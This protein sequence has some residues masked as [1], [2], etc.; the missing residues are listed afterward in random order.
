M[1]RKKDKQVRPQVAHAPQAHQTAAV[2]SAPASQWVLN[3]F[4]DIVLFIGAPLVVMGAFLPLRS[5]FT[6]QQIAV[7][8]LAFFT[9]GHHFP[10]FLR[11]YGDKELFARYRW[12]FLIAPPLIF[13]AALW[14][15]ARQLHGLLIF[16]A[17]WDIWHVLMQHYGFMRIY[18]SKAGAVSP[19]T[20]WMD[21]ALSISWYLALI[22]VSPHYSHN[23]LSRAAQVGLPLMSPEFLQGLRTGMTALSALLTLTYVGYHLWLWKQGRPVSF[24][25]LALLGIFLGATWYLYVGLDDF[26]VGFTVWSGFHCI[27]YYGIVWV[28]NRNRV[29]KGSP[30]TSFIRFLFRPSPALVVLYSAL[31][32]AYGSINYWAG[33]VPDETLRKLLL[34]FITTSNAL[35]YYFD[36]FIWKMRDSKTRQDLEIADAERVPI[37]AMGWLKQVV[38]RI[39]PVEHGGWQAAYLAGILLLLVGVE[40]VRPHDELK[41]QES[42]A[43][44]AP[45]SGEAQYNY[46]TA[47]LNARRVDEA[48]D[49]FRDA[50]RLMPDSSKVWNNLGGALYDKGELDESIASLEKA[51]ALYRPGEE[52]EAVRSSS[53]LLPGAAASTAARPDVVR[54]NLADALARSGRNEEAM[55]NYRQAIA[56]NPLSVKAHAGLGA[57]LTDVESYDEA[58]AELERAVTLDPDY[59]A[60]RINLASLL[61]YLGETEEALGHYR[62]ALAS[63]DER[64]RQAAAAAIAQLESQP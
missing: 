35:H 37:S 1:A 5:W 27:Q 8:L 30:L 60:A 64:A 13:A 62:V 58:R 40:T 54:A 59:A 38:R 49:V 23:L 20:S 42:L 51:L 7:F 28:Y 24:R 19:V 61:A 15:D 17:M 4:A 3:P 53:P 21:W 43:A 56:L 48:I 55:N 45:D 50:A 34:A 10:G 31:I 25:K 6:S 63:G 46:G 41:A 14:F 18:D 16:V 29:A 36:G 26:L 52:Q 32:M 47:L 22:V 12:R 39:A 11:A 33:G 9:F 2:A 44:L 57:T